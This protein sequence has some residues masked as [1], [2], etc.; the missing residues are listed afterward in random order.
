MALKQ[1]EA[2]IQL[3][4]FVSNI[5]RLSDT[6]NSRLKS[7]KELSEISENYQ[8]FY[9]ALLKDTSN[10]TFDKNTTFHLINEL[11][12][13]NSILESKVGLFTP[14]K[15]FEAAEIFVESVKEFMEGEGKRFW[16]LLKELIQLSKLLWQKMNNYRNKN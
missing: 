8:T 3:K 5:E 6:L 2:N 14:L 11:K 10:I 9:K 13:V 1:D 16:I 12:L 15:H 4:R 7:K